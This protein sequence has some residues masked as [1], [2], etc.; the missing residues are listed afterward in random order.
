MKRLHVLISSHE[1]SPYQGSECAVGWNIATRMAA[2]HDVTVFCAN[3][4]PLYRN[5]YSNAISDYMNKQGVIPGM[6]VVYVEQPSVT[7]RYA[8]IN[9]KLMTL[10]KGVGWQPLYYLGLD[11][12]HREAFRTAQDL[13]LD[14]FDVVHQLTPI[15]FLRP[16]YFWTSN[17]PF[18]WGPLG[19]MYKVP[20]VFARCGGLSSFL[21]E[22]A[23]SVNITR[24]V[25]RSC[26]FKDAV[27][28]AKRIW[29]VT[30][31]EREHYQFL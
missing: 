17:V 3:G 29:T 4:P 5:S 6:S 21:F 28:K 31:D 30:E 8:R 20:G 16:G 7:L 1:F 26:S 11:G 18:F 10:T 23:R 9:K 27:R 15:S 13:G 2:F 25:H 14:N 19:G 12:W 24:Q 22:T